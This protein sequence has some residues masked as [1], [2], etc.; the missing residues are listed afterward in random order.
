MNFVV[1]SLIEKLMT[2][3]G[4]NHEGGND[5]DVRAVSFKSELTNQELRKLICG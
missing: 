5:D 3:S 1:N 4:I 2:F